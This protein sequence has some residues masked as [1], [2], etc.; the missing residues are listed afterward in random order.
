MQPRLA[1]PSCR[2]A[3]RVL[4]A[5]LSL[6]LLTS[7]VT[8]EPKPLVPEKSAAAFDAR[9]MDSPELRK[10]IEQQLGHEL[11]V[12][13][14]TGTNGWNRELLTLAAYFYHPSLDVAR[15][16]WQ[17]AQA[18]EISAGA[19]PNPTVGVQPGY[20]FNAASGVLSPW[21]PGA[22]IDLPIETAG[23]RG[24]RISRA[25]Q[26]S[27]IA[28]CNLLMSAWKVRADVRDVLSNGDLGARRGWL[29]LQ[30]STQQEIIRRLEQRQKAGAAS[31]SDV[32]SARL[33]LAKMKNE[34]EL[35][36]ESLAVTSTRLAEAV[37]APVQAIEFS[38][39]TYKYDSVQIT[40]KQLLEF[41]TQA[42]QGRAD[43]RVALAE[44][45][46][47][48]LSLQLEVARQYPDIHLGTGYQWDQGE[49]KWS[50]L[51][52]SA[53]LP[54]LN[55]NQGPIAE[56]RLKREE[57]AAR[58]IAIQAK[59]SAD[60]DSAT[61]S[62]RAAQKR[63]FVM[64]QMRDDLQLQYEMITAQLKAG[65]ADHFDELAAF[66]ER[67]S[68]RMME[69]EAVYRAELALNQLEDALQRPL[70]NGSAP[71]PGEFIETN[72]RAAKEKP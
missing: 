24:L 51:N 19:R 68:F 47:A 28:R 6:A 35:V 58:F 43:I 4:C 8:Y 7:C 13:P 34:L 53:D 15:A 46:A 11:K 63:R 33:A 12:W 10:F 21:I 61:S 5:G 56:A 18:A 49:S 64:K 60:I 20:N 66:Q 41:R 40:H 9:R 14:P 67:V 3:I 54:V 27:E 57:A 1:E 48:Q 62:F 30:V 70:A 31:S 23:K 71:P 16:Q 22:T 25:R 52:V 72:P 17:A 69:D 45:E 55:R 44:Y 26:Q 32:L 36:N 59:I 42:L 50:F 2:R 65:A 39:I 37:G 29:G 38:G